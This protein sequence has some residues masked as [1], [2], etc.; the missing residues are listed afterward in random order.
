MIND[1]NTIGQISSLIF[2]AETAGQNN[3]QT[4]SQGMSDEHV[5]MYDSIIQN[6]YQEPDQDFTLSANLQNE[7]LFQ[8]LYGQTSTQTITSLQLIGT[9]SVEDMAQAL[10]AIQTTMKQQLSAAPSAKTA[11]NLLV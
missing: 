3:P 11:V 2:V 6:I 5:Q 9:Q 7:Q 8:T 10:S 4:Q 1:K